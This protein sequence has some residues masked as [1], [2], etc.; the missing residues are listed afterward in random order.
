MRNKNPFRVSNSEG[1][2]FCLN[3]IKDFSPT[4]GNLLRVR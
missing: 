1:V 2:Y 4:N 3:L